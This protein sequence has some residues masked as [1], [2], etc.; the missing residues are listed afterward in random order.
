MRTQL[1]GITIAVLGLAAP[2]ANA[3]PTYGPII[4]RGV[5]ADKMM[6]H[7]GSSATL[8]PTVQYRPTGTATFQ[9]VTGAGSCSGSNC[10]WEAV[11]TGLTPGAA[12]DYQIA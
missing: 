2:I 9:T 5:T 1:V 10:D 4:A 12:Y 3:A 7:W 6:V 8:T 11:I